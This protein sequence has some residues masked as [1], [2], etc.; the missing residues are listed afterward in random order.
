MSA[1]YTG[2][3]ECGAL[4][5]A[6][7]GEPFAVAACHCTQ[8]QRQSGSAFSMSMIVVREAFRWEQG[9]PASY[10][11]RAESGARK[12]CV[13]CPDCGVRIYNA[14][15]S[16]PRTFNVKPGTLDDTSWLEPAVHVWQASKQPWVPV[17]EGAPR[18]DRNPS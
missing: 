8:C 17:P 2:G 15:E 13:F 4:R 18:F 3:C 1:K 9:E 7:E 12:E 6:V 10:E 11:S 14:L 5:Y 16:M